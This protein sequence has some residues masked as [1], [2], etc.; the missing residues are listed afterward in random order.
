M[1]TREIVIWA[2]SECRSTMSLYREVRRL[3]PVPV[4]IVLWKHGAGDDV[5]SRREA[6]GQPPGE[7]ADLEAEGVGDDMEKGLAVIRAHGGAGAVHVFCVY[8]NSQT[9]RKL[10]LEAKRS[11]ARV[12]VYAEAPCEMCTGAKAFLKR[13]Y[14]RF[15]LPRKLRETCRAADLLLSQSGRSGMKRLVRLGWE[16]EK[17]VPFGYASPAGPDGFKARDFQGGVLRILH[18]GAETPHRDIGTLEKA[19]GV[20]GRRGVRVEFRHTGGKASPKELAELNGWA[21]V[22]VACGV[23]EPWGMR[24]NDAVHAGIPVVVSRGMGAEWLVEKNGCGC[25]FEPRA[26]DELADILE[27]FARDARF[28]DRLASGVAAAHEEWLPENKAKEFLELISLRE[29]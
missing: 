21:D 4:K 28:R 19:I 1:N 3:S 2:H 8:Q 16:R 22:F 14:Y 18:T 9:W 13:L 25:T 15:V 10:L 26:S 6:C 27:R 7:Y 29:G 5:R 23:S 17:I 20:L 12:V 11:G 24:V